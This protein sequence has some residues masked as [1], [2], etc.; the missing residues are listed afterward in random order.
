MLLS[1]KVVANFIQIIS[2]Q[3]TKDK[4]FKSSSSLIGT[5]AK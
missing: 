1:A 4:S 5:E 3:G 2:K